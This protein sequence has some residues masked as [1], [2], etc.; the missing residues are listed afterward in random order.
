MKKKPF[1]NS[2]CK[3]DHHLLIKTV[4]NHFHLDIPQKQIP[5]FDFAD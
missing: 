5:H 4:D 1:N 2:P 3:N